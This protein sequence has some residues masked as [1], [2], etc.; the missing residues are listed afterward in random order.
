MTFVAQL[1]SRASPTRLEVPTRP[2]AVH[3]DTRSVAF[4]ECAPGALRLVSDHPR[5]LHLRYSSMDLGAMG[6]ESG[7]PPSWSLEE[8]PMDKVPCLLERA[9][10]LSGGWFVQ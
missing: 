9:A 1:A 8:E 3:V 5:I 10:T 4:G 2:L 6:T 7:V